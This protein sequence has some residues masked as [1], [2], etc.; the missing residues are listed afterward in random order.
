MS[1][2][3]SI[4]TK[5]ATGRVAE[6]FSAVEGRLG[7]VP[8][9]LRALANSPA[10]LEGYLSF[11]AALDGGALPPKLREQVAIAMAEANGCQ[12][13]L[14]INCALGR[15]SGLSEEEIRDSRASRS[16]DSR[17]HAALQFARRVLDARGRVD[18]KDLSRIRRAGFSDA[19]IAELVGNIS[20]H[21]FANYFNCVVQTTPDVPCAPAL[22]CQSQPNQQRSES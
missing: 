15:A 3:G 20:L 21:I 9:F 2:L 10:T 8:N 14:A 22:E 11:A 16:P 12:Y 18:D 6:L 17:T 1:R 7:F 13:C 4:E 19:E 5:E